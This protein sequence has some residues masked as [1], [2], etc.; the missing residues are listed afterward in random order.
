M[1]VRTLVCVVL[2]R[3]KNVNY[4][5]SHSASLTKKKYIFLVHGCLSHVSI[6]VILL[7]L[8]RSARWQE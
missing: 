3:A 7:E 6:N 8:N 2:N 1:A 5:A 4:V